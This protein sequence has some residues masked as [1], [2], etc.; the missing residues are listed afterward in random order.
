M[1][2]T[3]AGSTALSTRPP[4]PRG[5]RWAGNLMAY[6]EDRLGFLLELR[7]RY[8]AI[9]AFDDQTTIINDVDLAHEVLTNRQ[10][11]FAILGNF[12][13]ERVTVRQAGAAAEALT[14]LGPGLRRTAV[15]HLG[16]Q[17]S[18]LI[19]QAFPRTTTGAAMALDPLPRLEDVLTRVT[20]GHYFGDDWATVQP[21]VGRLLARL[22]AVFGSPFALPSFVP[23]PS[24]LRIRFAYRAARAV[25]DPLIEARRRAPE[26]DDYVAQ[27]VRRQQLA[28]ATPD[29]LAD[30]VIGSMLAAHR[31][32]AIG[33]AWALLELAHRPGLQEDLA[34]ES[35]E[36]GRTSDALSPLALAVILEALR[37][38]PPTWILNRTVTEPTVL[39][40]YELAPGH[41]LIISPYVIHRDPAVFENPLAFDVDRWRNKSAMR[42]FLGFGRGLH[43]CPGQHLGLATMTS[44]L[45]AIVRNWQLEPDPAGSSTLPEDPR[46]SLVPVRPAI[47][48]SAR[49]GR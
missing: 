45:A 1:V 19:E 30:L 14:T 29:R 43:L 32:P 12:R 47:R 17:T 33:V 7:E 40:G 31:I 26:A 37:L 20:Y 48:F 44:A 2:V 46:S 39:D 13:S 11:A 22:A 24:R 38:H 34:A 36:R 27:V 28:H 18:R 42:G 21:V 16:P 9:V 15:T 10:R 4:G 23:T 6:E 3:T 8:G 49:R 5:D 35:L 25:I 41:R